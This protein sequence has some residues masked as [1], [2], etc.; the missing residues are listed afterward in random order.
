[1]HQ[2]ASK[3]V[4]RCYRQ[5]ISNRNQGCGAVTCM[6]QFVQR[7]P[8]GQ[9]PKPCCLGS[10]RR[11]RATSP[12]IFLPSPGAL[13]FPNRS[14]LRLAT[15][16]DSHSAAT[17][18]SLLAHRSLVLGRISSDTRVVSAVKAEPVRP[19]RAV[20]SRQPG[21]NVRQLQ[22][23]NYRIAGLNVGDV[24][25]HKTP[26]SPCSRGLV[27][28]CKACRSSSITVS[29][30]RL[31]Q[32]GP[33]GSD[34]SVPITVRRRQLLTGLLVSHSDCTICK[35]HAQLAN[36][37]TSEAQPGLLSARS[38]ADLQTIPMLSIVSALPTNCR[39]SRW[40]VVGREQQHSMHWQCCQQG[41]VTD[42]WSD[43]TSPMLQLWCKAASPSNSC[44]ACNSPTLTASVA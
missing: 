21:F 7:S 42:N 44:P 11:W 15:I 38:H 43:V 40:H 23:C 13:Y 1:M 3:Y 30:M 32:D 2:I 17:M 39:T 19:V 25:L 33:R 18:A 28:A 8:H 26:V 41:R 35:A 20:I 14:G 12:T 5:R 34:C 36:L 37:R 29:A 6:Y 27:A 31:K 9:M 10:G 4:A 22:V 24:G 16:G